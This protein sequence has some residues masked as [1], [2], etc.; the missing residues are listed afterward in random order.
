MRSRSVFALHVCLAEQ[1]AEKAAEKAA[2]Q[3]A[4][5]GKGGQAKDSLRLVGGAVIR[6]SGSMVTSPQALSSNRGTR[7][8]GSMWM[9]KK[10]L[11][12]KGKQ[13]P[14]LLL[15]HAPLLLHQCQIITCQ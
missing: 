1:A 2:E 4:E 10:R 3:V 5:R 11:A 9:R 14:L 7:G 6:E 12:C 15:T 13:L 8:L